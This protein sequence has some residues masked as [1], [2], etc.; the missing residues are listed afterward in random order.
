MIIGLGCVLACRLVGVIVVSGWLLCCVLDDDLVVLSVGLVVGS[1]VLLCWLIAINSVVYYI[2]LRVVFVLIYVCDL[3]LLFSVVLFDC[4]WVCYDV[5]YAVSLGVLGICDIC[6]LLG[7]F[8]FLVLCLVC[9][10]F[11]IVF[12]M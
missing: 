10:W 4:C 12:V 11:W 2:W 7:G 1:C 9:G 8:W 5:G 3:M 6:Y